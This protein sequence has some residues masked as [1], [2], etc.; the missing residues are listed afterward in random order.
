V[1]RIILTVRRRNLSAHYYRAFTARYKDFCFMS[2]VLLRDAAWLQSRLEELWNTYYSDAPTAYPIAIHFGPRARYRYGSIYSIGKQCHIL[3]NRLFAY[4]EVPEHVI[5]ATICHELAHYVHGYG[6][7]LRK[8]YANPHRGGVVDKEMKARGCWHLE[9][10]ASIWRKDCWKGLYETHATDAARRKQERERRDRTRWEMYLSTPEFRTSEGLES[11]LA[12][13]C[14]AF[15]YSELPFKVEWLQASPRRNGLSYL[16]NSDSVVRVHGVLADNM[17]PDSVIRYELSYWL[18]VLKTGGA[19]SRVEK[20]MKE[21]GVWPCAQQ[22][23]RWRRNIWPSYY[24][25][26]HPLRSK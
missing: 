26:S 15:G 19:W 3:I 2:S 25:E 20:A 8:R 10:T 23:I 17:V 21:A 1:R 16:F 6:S 22:A 5:D 7:G 9:E 4:P 12:S 14:S 24:V 18:A 13:L 11:E